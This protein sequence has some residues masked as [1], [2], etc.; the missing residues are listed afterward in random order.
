MVKS[1]YRESIAILGRTD[2]DV[3]PLCLGGNVFG[4]TA[5]EPQSQ[6]V[7]DAY[8]DAGGNFVDTA[9]SY[10]LEHGR[11]ET[12][13]GAWMASRKNR[14]EIVLGTKVGGGRGQVRNLRPENIE[15]EAHASLERLQTD[16]ID[17]YFAH[18]DDPETPLEDTLRA[19]DALAKAGIVRHIG[20]SNY[21]PERLT[22]A[23]ELQQE[24][25]LVEFTV[26]QPHYNLVEREFENTLM[27]VA[28]AWDLAVTPYYALAS[29]FL[30][31]KYRPGGEKVESPRAQGARAYLD[32]GGAAVLELLDDIAKTHETTVAAVALAWLL[33]RPRV[34]SPIASART[35]QQLEQILPAVGLKLTPEETDR[36]SKTTEGR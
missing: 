27:P 11:S 35:T 31:G 34:V 24:L 20:A 10:L 7:L 8:R 26:L 29:G 15:R 2:L 3:F 5:D 25:G 23:L 21:T 30:S 1:R 13:I 36:L 32:K 28:D 33:T 9:N 17:L 16:R 4:W 19:F 12:I 18:F 14:D 22:A 6:S